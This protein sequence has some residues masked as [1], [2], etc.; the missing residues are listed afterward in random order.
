[1]DLLLIVLILICGLIALYLYW[2]WSFSYWERQG[3][4]SMP[5]VL[6]I[7]GH[8]LPLLLLQK[9]ISQLAKNWYNRYSEA[10][11]IGYFDGMV[12]GLLV[13]DPD[14]VKTVIQTNFSNFHENAL[15]V[16]RKND[17][18]LAKNPFFTEGEEWL[19]G[20]KRLTYAFSSMRLKILAETVRGVCKKFDHYLNRKI[21]EDRRV[22]FET[23]DLFGRFTGEVV[24]NAAF[25]IE[26]FCFE[27]NYNSQS[28]HNIGE[29]IFRVT[30][31]NGTVQS[32]ML[33]LPFLH[34]FFNFRFIPKDIDQFF[35]SIV[36]QVIEK[37]RDETEKRNDFFQL[38]ADL[39]KS[40]G[41]KFDVESLTAHA[42]SFFVDGYET[43]SATLSFICFEL[44]IHYEVQEKVRKEIRDVLAKHGGE[45][46]YDSLKEMTY[47]DQVIN[48]SQRLN[49]L[50]DM[51]GKICT[52]NIQLKGNDGLTCQ[53]E[54]G[55]KI[56][57]PIHCLQRDPKYW[58]NPEGFDPDRWNNEK[59]AD[60]NKYC[61]LPFG[62]GPRICVGLRMGLLQIKAALVT[63]L[64]KYRIE[65]N[66]RTSY[67]V[68]IGLW[69]I[70]STP[71][72]GLWV[73]LRR[74]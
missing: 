59:K 4:P 67:P 28:F 8:L 30:P 64:S 38:M 3:I 27:D 41:Q 57:I 50:L 2:R 54:P 32:I 60:V 68:K 53:V 74:L 49:T 48:E 73:Y 51:M 63:L 24:A 31:F 35:R 12:P 22:Q 62:E 33:F 61:F 52:N 19:T 37:R 65:R 55:T 14:L 69:G 21:G 43:S 58:I 36:E 70:L 10:S 17:P 66:P 42:L 15:K 7:V 44:S 13:R 46:T 18:L 72:E 29:K 5:F 56:L 47:M 20:R 45:L 1:M 16:D 9:N 34:K 40:E 11:M 6:P 25:G 39:E 26:G 71:V 23:K